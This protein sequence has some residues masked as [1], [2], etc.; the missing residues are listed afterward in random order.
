MVKGHEK[1]VSV[2]IP[3]KNERESVESL[4][5]SV[6]QQGYRP[7]EVVVVDGASTDGTLEIIEKLK[8]DLEGE[9]F[10]LNMLREE[11]FGPLRSPANGRN[12]G[13]MNSSGSYVVL[14]DADMILLDE[15]FVEKVK[16]G[17]DVKPW[18]MTRLKPMTDSTLEEALIIDALPCRWYR[19]HRYCGVRRHLFKDRL[20]DPHL[21][22]GEDRDF[23]DHHLEGNLKIK[24]L[25]VDVY[26]GVHYPHT[27]KEFFKQNIWYGKT[28]SLYFKKHYS[29]WSV[30]VLRAIVGPVTPLLPI[31]A[32]TLS[33]MLRNLPLFA[34]S[35]VLL[36][37]IA[38]KIT[39]RKFRRHINLSTQYGSSKVLL[40]SMAIDYVI[41]PLAWGYGLLA[42]LK[43]F[44]TEKNQQARN[45]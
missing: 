44:F 38:Y 40:L 45:S 15:G 12:I 23:F 28:V 17:L 30:E 37:Y 4:I 16:A 19:V 42:Y 26:A 11:E 5:R 8:G 34:L 6:H 24:P 43:H 31:L 18:V 3:V 33:L 39:Y 35:T 1:I 22:F 2:I 9:S 27:L 14:L 20:F 29:F 10:K 21:G 36:V 32:L 25:L 13:L 7:I 41:R